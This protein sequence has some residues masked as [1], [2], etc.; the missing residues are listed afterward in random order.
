MKTN[1]TYE[2]QRRLNL[3]RN[4]GGILFCGAGF[5]ADCL[6]FQTDETIGTGA[7][8]LNLFNG[9]LRQDPPYKDLRNA[10][11]ALWEKIA[12]HGMETLLKNRFNVSNVTSDMADLLRYPWQGVYTT[13]YDNALEIS[14]QAA[15]I[16]ADDLNNTDDPNIATQNLPIIHL[17]GYVK[18]WDI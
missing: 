11:D 16:Q 5:S 15:H 4:G 1:A 12:D 17:H 10:A 7:Q 8:L 6:N 3:A 13:N 18:K 14:A 2:F 9:E